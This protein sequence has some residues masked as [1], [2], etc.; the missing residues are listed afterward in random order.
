MA[1]H[2]CPVPPAIHRL[3]TRLGATTGRM[4]RITAQEE[5]IAASS[6]RIALPSTCFA[7]LLGRE[8]VV[9]ERGSARA[10]LCRTGVG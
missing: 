7:A 2:L 9:A 1:G 3:P 8:A 5:D 6:T 10:L 4:T